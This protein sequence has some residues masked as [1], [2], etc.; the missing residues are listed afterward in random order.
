MEHYLQMHHSH[1]LL[2]YLLWHVVGDLVTC[3]TTILLV[4]RTNQ[5]I[6]PIELSDTSE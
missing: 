5:A 1:L 3:S 2:A 6:S 4:A